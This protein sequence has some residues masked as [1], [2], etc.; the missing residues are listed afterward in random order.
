M[1]A[2]PTQPLQF[3]IDPRWRTMMKGLTSGALAGMLLIAIAAVLISV[4]SASAADAAGNETTR[5]YC[6]INVEC[7]S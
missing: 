1:A 3:S 2:D 5:S 6:G 7:A 4:A